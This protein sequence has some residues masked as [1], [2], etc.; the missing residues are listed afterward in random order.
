MKKLVPIGRIEWSVITPW[1]YGILISCVNRSC[2]DETSS[3]KSTLF[4]CDWLIIKISYFVMTIGIV[5]DVVHFLEFRTAYYLTSNNLQ[6]PT[7]PCNWNC[8]RNGKRR[9]FIHNKFSNH[10]LWMSRSWFIQ[11]ISRM[12]LLFTEQDETRENS[13]LTFFVYLK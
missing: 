8:H 4:L 7:P 6:S 11:K 12:K 5:V 1:N 13:K 9:E 10:Q 2:Y 3:F